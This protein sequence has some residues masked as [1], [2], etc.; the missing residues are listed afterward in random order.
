ML[1]PKDINKPGIIIEFKRA[2]KTNKKS[3]EE[4][5]EEARKQIEYKKYETELLNRVIANIKKLL[6]VFKAKEVQL[7][8]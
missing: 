5:I 8:M 1:I 6:I 2:R 7:M 3:I 4:L